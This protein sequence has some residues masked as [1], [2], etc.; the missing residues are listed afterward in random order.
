MNFGFFGSPPTNCIIL[1]FVIS[2]ISM[3]ANKDDDDDV[4][5]CQ[6]SALR[7]TSMRIVGKNFNIR[8]L[9]PGL[10]SSCIS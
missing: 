1:Y 7:E 3:L 6:S 5:C 8:A 2:I 10:L 4:V 9:I